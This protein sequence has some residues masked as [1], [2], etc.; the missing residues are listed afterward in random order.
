MR[1]LNSTI[2]LIALVSTLTALAFCHGQHQGLAANNARP[3]NTVAAVDTVRSLGRN[4]DCILQDKNGHYWF[5]SNGDGLYRYDGRALVH[6]TPQNSSLCSNFVW[7]IQQDSNGTIWFST[8][9]GFCAF[10]GTGFTDHTGKIQNAP[11]GKPHFSKDAIFFGHLNGICVYDGFSFTNFNI[12]P[13]SYNP[14]PTDMSRP[15]SIYSTLVD[16]DGNWWFGT[17]SKGVCRYD[18]STVSFLT[19]KHLAA[20]AVRTLFQDK[21]GNLW[22]GNNGA[23]LFR[24]DGKTLTNVTDEKQL[25]NLEFLNGHFN[26]KPGSLA[27]VWAINEDNQGNLWIGTIDAGLWKFQNNDLVNYTAN[28]AL[29]GNAV[30]NIYKDHLGQLWYVID[31]KTVGKFDG[32][33]FTKFPF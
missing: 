11:Y 1:I 30:W 20:A 14:S 22:F 24:Y 12:A 31:G 21:K 28:D 19:E 3:T 9:D 16:K 10:N 6:F 17:Q 13:D 26:D 2:P 25:G 7:N 15:Y 23:G 5:A 29:P 33:T 18:G 4:I 8:R 27:R 32:H